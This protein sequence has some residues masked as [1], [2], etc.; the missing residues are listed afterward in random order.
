LTIEDS[1]AQQQNQGRAEQITPLTDQEQHTTDE[2]AERLPWYQR[3]WL[4]DTLQERREN[5]CGLVQPRLG[6]DLCQKDSWKKVPFLLFEKP[7][8]NLQ[9]Q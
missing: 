6:V 9:G 4:G 5:L 1:T 3:H 2:T 7:S 8:E